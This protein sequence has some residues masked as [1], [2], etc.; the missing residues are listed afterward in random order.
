[1]A[2]PL[3]PCAL[4]PGDA[5]RVL[6]LASPV[7]GDLLRQGCEELRRLGFHPR[8]E[9]SAALAR[10]GTFAGSADAR[11]AALRQALAEPGTCGLFCTRGG[12]GSNYLLECL[13][14]D[15]VPAAPRVLVGASDLSS[16]QIY[17]WEKFGWISFYGPM[18]ATAFS[19]GAGAANGYD[20]ESLLA[21]L[22]NKERGWSVDLQGETLTAGNASG[23]LLG[24]CLTLIE[25]ALATP[26]ELQTEGSILVIEDRGMK[27]YAVD[28]S[29][30]HLRQAGKFRGV[31]GFILGDFPDC[32]PSPGDETVRDVVQRVLGPLSIPMVYGS[33]VGHTSRPVL[34]LPLGVRARLVAPAGAAAR[35]EILE[36]ACT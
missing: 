23:V 35:I 27:P 9:E 11:F 17:L 10:E 14:R 15:V 2:K 4:K 28:R 19:R 1:M 21:A 8:V 24:G 22:T 36:P 26:W 32:E 34:T 33:P 13:K 20:R 7:K 31:T 25:T 18:V 29:L 30:M 6:S 16:L 3:K 12:Y 5:V